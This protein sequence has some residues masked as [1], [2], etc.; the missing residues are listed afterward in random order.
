MLG[1]SAAGDTLLFFS[2]SKAR[3]CSGDAKCCKS[4][5]VSIIMLNISVPVTTVLFP[6]QLQPG[7]A[8]QMALLP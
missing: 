1:S 4:V 7:S 2:E 3:T 8:D 6:A 5:Q